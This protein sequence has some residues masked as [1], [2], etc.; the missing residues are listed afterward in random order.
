SFRRVSLDE[1]G[2]DDLVEEVWD[3]VGTDIE[4]T[5]S[6]YDGRL[7]DELKESAMNKAPVG[8]TVTDP[9]KPDNPLIYVNKAF[10]RITGYSEQ[11]SVGRNCRFL[12][13]DESQHEKIARMSEA[14][15]EER[16]VSV[17][18]VNYRKNGEK[19]W[20]RVDFAPLKNS[21]GDAVYFV[22]FQMDIT[23]RKKAERRAKRRA[24]EVEREREKLEYLVGRIRGI[25]EDIAQLLVGA[26]RRQEFEQGVCDMLADSEP[27]VCAWIGE[28]GISGNVVRPRSW[29]ASKETRIQGMEGLTVDLDDPE[30]ESDPVVRAIETGSLQV[31]Q[32]GSSDSF[33][34]QWISDSPL[35]LSSMA[36]VPLVY[37]ETTYGTLNLY[38]R[39]PDIFDEREKVI[40]NSLGSMV[41]GIVNAFEAEKNLADRA[42]IELEIRLDDSEVF[43]DDVYRGSR[44]G[45]EIEVLFDVK[46]TDSVDT[47]TDAA[48]EN[49]E[50]TDVSLVTRD[51]DTS[52]FEFTV[53]NRSIVKT[54]SE[55]AA[56]IISVDASQKGSRMKV[57]VP[58]R[59]SAKSVMEVLRDRYTDVELVSYHEKER[60]GRTNEEFVTQVNEVLTDKQRTALERAYAGGFFDWPR[61]VSGEELADSMG[62]SK[63]TFHQHLRAAERKMMD[64]FFDQRRSR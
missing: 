14:V 61:G 5:E 62:I 50:I 55:Y 36:S 34:P 12:Q 26:E 52:L 21:E 18:L 23:E 63:S 31:V 32:E 41:A 7:P 64:E 60:P 22:G 8:I 3:V 10:E 47:F 38:S 44:Y 39:Q 6:A 29:S 24:E 54:L 33:H 30:V 19:F 40:L 25:V 56:K 35:G 58:D 49:P 13:G 42:G 53:S 2:Y 37:K 17:E 45:D 43:F 15:E 51:E 48:E 4:K 11:D 27:Y 46:G 1:N 28:T 20:N 59:M 9:D 57:E 16:P